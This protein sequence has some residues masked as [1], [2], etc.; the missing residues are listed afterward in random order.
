MPNLV[1]PRLEDLPKF[2]VLGN[3]KSHS[4]LAFYETEVVLRS[5][6]SAVFVMVA[7]VSKRG[8]TPP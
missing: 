3:I 4:R 2:V 7:R 8:V 6:I 1:L 5:G